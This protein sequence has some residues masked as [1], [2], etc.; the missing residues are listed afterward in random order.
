MPVRA[1]SLGIFEPALFAPTFHFSVTELRAWL[2]E[3]AKWPTFFA[4]SIR[5]TA[6]AALNSW[7]D[8]VQMWTRPDEAQ[9]AIQP[10]SLNADFAD[11]GS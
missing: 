10:G 8:I 4:Q 2:I 5:Q 7:L 11:P 3:Q 6:L 9:S 1:G